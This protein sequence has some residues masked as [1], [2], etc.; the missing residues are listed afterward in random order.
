MDHFHQLPDDRSSGFGKDR[1]SLERFEQQ[2]SGNQERSMNRSRKS[3]FFIATSC[4]ALLFNVAGRHSLAAGEEDRVGDADRTLIRFLADGQEVEAHRLLDENFVWI[5][6]NGSEANESQVLQQHLKPANTDVSAEVRIYGQSAIVRANRGKMQVMRVW[7]KRPVGWR[8]VLY[9]EVKLVEESEPPT[10]AGAAS[11]ECENPC[12]SIPFEPKTQSEK[13]AI[14]SWQGVMRAMANNDA[15]AYAPLI[16]DEFTATDTHHDRPY[17]KP[18]RIAQINKQKLVGAR[19][20]PPAL[21]S[22]RMF[23][24]GETVMMIAREQ[25]PSA[26]AYFNTRMWVKRDGLWQMLFSFNTRIE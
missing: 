9:Q 19:S 14:A 23:D 10:G 12:N 1:L 21:L 20:T 4:A 16:A 11:G 17:T 15:N 18:D 3:F 24:F 6:S 26:K 5:D 8:A 7:V 25:R 2:S 13:E 22:A